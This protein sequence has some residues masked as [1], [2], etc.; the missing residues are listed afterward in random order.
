MTPPQRRLRVSAGP[1]APAADVEPQRSWVEDR[2]SPGQR[3]A[4]VSGCRLQVDLKYPTELRV[5]V[6]RCDCQPVRLGGGSW[7]LKSGRSTGPVKDDSH[8]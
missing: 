3:S 2:E 6:A 1:A 8:R 4:L 5:C 7:L